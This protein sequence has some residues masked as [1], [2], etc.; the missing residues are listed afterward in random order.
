MKLY[1]YKRQVYAAII[2]ALT[3]ALF[4][5]PPSVHASTGTI[6]PANRY[7]YGENIGWLDFGISAGNVTV[8]DSALTGYAYGENVGW[9]SL[10]C[11]NTSSC[12]T[13]DYKVSNT[14]GTLAGYAYGEN[15]GWLHFN[16]AGA[17]VTIDSSGVFHGAAYGENVGWIVFNCADT[18]SC[19]TVDYKV[20]TTWRP[21]SGGTGGSGGSG[22]SYI[23]PSSQPNVPPP[24]NPPGLQAPLTMPPSYP[25]STLVNY[26]GTIY[27]ITEPYVAVGFTS[28][29]AFVGLGYKLDNVIS[30]N[31][32]GYRLADSYFLSS[33]TQSHP[34]SSWV[35][36]RGTVY[37]IGSQGLIGVPSWDIFLSNGGLA[38]YLVPANAND[39]LVLKNHPGLPVL[40]P[41]DSRVIR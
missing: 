10:N 27:L 11:A 9:L 19:G 29:P 12:G 13:V 30:D 37:Y 22:G 5:A 6:E 33:P 40:V 25:P 4:F 2:A 31:L 41:N 8:T 14:N 3:I 16:P 38:Q 20:I 32:P 28:W 34:W 15:V 36:N 1:Y 35:I 18:A 17:G 24:A 39:L 7:A 23:P 26:Q 21:A